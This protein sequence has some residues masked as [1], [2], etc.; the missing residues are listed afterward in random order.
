LV[1]RDLWE[2]CLSLRADIKYPTPQ[3]KALL[4]KAIKDVVP[5]E[6]T[7]RR[8]KTFFTDTGLDRGS[9]VDAR[10][11]IQTGDFRFE[12]IDYML[13]VDRLESRTMTIRELDWAQ[14]L[15]RSHAFLAQ[16]S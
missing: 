6:V 13:L 10:K 9:W 2:F 1:D 8:H 12:G 15:A 4:R 5:P 3:D 7:A 11:W 16:W 14:N